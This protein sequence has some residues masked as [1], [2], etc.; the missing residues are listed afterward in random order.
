MNKTN[1]WGGGYREEVNIQGEDN[2][3]KDKGIGPAQDVP[4]TLIIWYVSKIVF[5]S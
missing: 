2:Y 3:D 4:F 1:R 5:L